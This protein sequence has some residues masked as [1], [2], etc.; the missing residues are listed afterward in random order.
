MP[1]LA[2]N[3][4]LSRPDADHSNGW[5]ED[6]LRKLA[7]NFGSSRN[8]TIPA[9]VQFSLEGRYPT[10]VLVRGP[11]EGDAKL[12]VQ[13]TFRALHG[14][15]LGMCAGGHLKAATLADDGLSIAFPDP[16][17]LKKVMHQLGLISAEE[18][19]I[20]LVNSEAAARG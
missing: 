12:A 18:A 1:V 19:L 3:K 10:R 9:A 4:Y 5:L 7:V 13:D 8:T 2:N 11:L 6:A 20:P 15:H 17:G 14:V 16:S